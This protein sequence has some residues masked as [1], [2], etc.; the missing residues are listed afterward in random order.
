MGCLAA[1]PRAARVATPTTDSA[2]PSTLDHNSSVCIAVTRSLHQQKPGMK[3]AAL[4]YQLVHQLVSAQAEVHFVEQCAE[5]PDLP[6]VVA[7]LSR[8]AVT[9][10]SP[11]RT[12][13][14]MRVI[15]IRE[16]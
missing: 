5:V 14:R 11:G 9:Y 8:L 6:S 4:L 7:E 15:F 1:L 12:W 10:C 13:F 2:M 3:T 16:F